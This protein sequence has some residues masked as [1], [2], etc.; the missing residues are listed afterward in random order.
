MTHQPR[1]PTHRDH[2]GLH[3]P[4]RRRFF[5]RSQ[6]AD[7]AVV[8]VIR[9]WRAPRVK[10]LLVGCAIVGVLALL[11]GPLP[12][13]SAHAQAVLNAPPCDSAR[14]DLEAALARPQP[15]QPDD[16]VRLKLQIE[17]S[18]GLVAQRCF[19]RE[20]DSAGA[21]QRAAQNPLIVPPIVSTMQGPLA[22]PAGASAPAGAAPAGI[23]LP[24]DV[25]RPTTLSTCD[26]G[27]CWDS[28]GQRYNSSGPVL[29]GPR[30]TCVAQAGVV[31]CN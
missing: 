20:A 1:I 10:D 27:G 13:S 15:V 23:P 30:G 2:N 16:Q 7:G 22:A 5:L 25:G 6:A 26:P 4:L 17:R 28:N 24:V 21:A 12:M 9:Y 19:N 11:G 14:Q 3:A 29:N 8:P 18:R 31:T